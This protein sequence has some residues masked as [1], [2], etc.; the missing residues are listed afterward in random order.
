M[1]KIQINV[2]CGNQDNCRVE[3]LKFEVVDLDSPYHA[4]LGRPH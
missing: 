1:G 4:L 3:N 2:I